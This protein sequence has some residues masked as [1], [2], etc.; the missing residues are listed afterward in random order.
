MRALLRRF[1]GMPEKRGAQHQPL[2]P[3]EYEQ[4]RAHCSGQ[5][6]ASAA[7][8]L[9]HVLDHIKTRG[10]Q[11]FSGVA[12]P[13]FRRFLKALAQEYPISGVSRTLRDVHLPCSPAHEHAVRGYKGPP[14]S[15]AC[16]LRRCA[17]CRAR[18]AAQ[19]GAA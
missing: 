2:T 13:T 3:P 16:T 19:L 14:P 10:G 6:P 11:D 12:P 9:G 15:P 8:C 17:S 5:V 7:H 1:A 18:S 4:L